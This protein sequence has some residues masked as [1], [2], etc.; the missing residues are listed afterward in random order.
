MSE[1][2]NEDRPPS[3]TEEAV[4]EFAREWYAAWNAHDVQ[5]VLSHYTE[6]IVFTSPLAVHGDS[7]RTMRGREKVA[8][9]VRRA[10]EKVPDLHF[11]PLATLAAPSS[12]V[13]HYRGV[14]GLLVAE[15]MELDGSGRAQRV[16][17]HYERLPSGSP[18]SG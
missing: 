12:V 1:R 18:A 2:S 3:L 13:L 14:F 16:V 5:R 11:E 10:F 8:E 15:F 4:G 6:D 7:T 9:H 17:A